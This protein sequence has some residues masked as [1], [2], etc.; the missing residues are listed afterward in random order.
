MVLP[1]VFKAPRI[2]LLI[3]PTREFDRG[4]LQG[5]ARYANEYGPWTFYR[6]P[7]HYQPLDWEQKVTNRLRS[8]QVDAIIMREPDRIDEIIRCG[9][10]G[11]CAPITRRTVEGFINIVID[12]DKVGRLAAEHLLHCGFSHF[13]FCGFEGIYPSISR[14]QAFQAR[15]KEAGYSC[16]L[17][18]QPKGKGV[19]WEK[20]E[21]LLVKWLRSLPK[22]VG[23]LASN[24][25][26]SQ[27]LLDACHLAR[28]HVPSE[29]GIIGVGNDE[30]ICRLANPP[31]SS[32]G[33]N[34]EPLGYRAAQLLDRA[35]VEK[36]R[37]HAVVEGEP[38]HVV[39][40]SSTNILL[41][42]DEEMA[43]AVRFIRENSDRPLQVNDVAEAVGISRRT[44]QYRFAKAIGRSV[45]SQILRERVNRI[46]QLLVETDLTVTQIADKLDFS[47]PKQLDRVFTR[48]QGMPP[49]AY[50]TRYCVK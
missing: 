27:H 38:T 35:L 29:V 3:A 23:I 28:I 19:L 31:L 46:T 11:I 1:T 10:P 43:E 17:Y 40:R 13:G 39:A 36:T 24:D 8:G 18:E 7:P 5:I 32:I 34:A 26:R 33:L 9:I 44:L 42:Q 30:F 6:E 14:A 49:T 41:V 45:H 16:H 47:S 21:P 2:I 15:L 22:P 12:N 20:E 25:D 4:L 50:R 37:C 48:F